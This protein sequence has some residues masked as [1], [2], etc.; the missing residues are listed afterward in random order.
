MDASG[1]LQLV[2]LG[3][4]LLVGAARPRRV[5]R[6]RLLG[7]A[8]SR[9]PRL[10]AGRAC[11][12]PRRRRDTG[13]RAALDGLRAFGA[14]LQ[15]RLGPRPLPAPARPGRALPQPDRRD[16][17]S[18]GARLQHRRQLRHEHELAEL[19]RRV[20]DEPPHADER[21]RRPELRLGGGRHRGRDRARP[22]HH[23][24]PQR[25]DRQLLGRPHALRHAHPAPA[26]RRARTRARR[27]RARSR[28]STASP[29][30]VRSRAR[31][32]RSPA[33]RS[34][35]RRRSR[36]S[37]RTAAGRSTRTRRI[38]SRTRRRSR[39]CSRS[40]RCS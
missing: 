31:R 20:D 2:A 3:L 30:P 24:A 22:R 25:D 9:G 14:R 33:G 26:L 36:S 35:A 23:A 29:R 8:A 7:R 37:A 32:R 13:E 38:R 40:S 17:R 19:R 15:R 27:A 5:H 4:A 12:L 21:A 10:R 18:A 16:G 28:A 34:R 6:P 11:D 1:W 39:T